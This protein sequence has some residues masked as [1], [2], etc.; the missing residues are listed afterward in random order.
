MRKLLAIAQCYR[1]GTGLLVLAS[2]ALCASAATPK[3]VLILNS[4]EREVAPFNTVVSAFRTTL[5]RE[6]GQ[7][8]ERPEGGAYFCFRLPVTAEGSGESL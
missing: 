8:V 6:L 4:F 7:P 1:A 5:V 3:R 2:A